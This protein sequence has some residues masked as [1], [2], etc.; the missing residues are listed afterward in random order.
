M[1]RWFGIQVAN[2]RKFS[3]ATWATK[4]AKI[5]VEESCLRFYDSAYRYS[6]SSIFYGDGRSNPDLRLWFAK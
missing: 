5:K 6:L 2:R 3:W 1:S 4:A